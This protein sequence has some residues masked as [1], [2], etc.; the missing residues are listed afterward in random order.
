MKLTFVAPFGLRPKSTVSVRM[1]PL[2]RELVRRGHDVTL[3][4]PPWDNP[5]DSGVE[6]DDHGVHVVNLPLPGRPDPLAASHSVILGEPGAGA[7]GAG[8]RKN[9]EGG[10]GGPNS[11]A[12]SPNRGRPLPMA[13][14]P[15]LTLRLLNRTTATHPDIVHAF[16]PKG[17][18]GAVAQALLARQAMTG[19]RLPV[20]VDTD[21]WEGPGG[22]NDKAA[23]PH[24]QQAI[25]AYQ[26][27]WLLRHAHAVTAA[28]QT[29]VEMA[30]ALREGTGRRG[31]VPQEWAL[32]ARNASVIARSDA[33][34]PWQSG[35]LAARAPD[36]HVAP[37]FMP[38]RR[39]LAMTVQRLRGTPAHLYGPVPGPREAQQQAGPPNPTVTY[40][41]NG[42][43]AVSTTSH[44]DTKALRT[45]LK[46]G[47]APVLLLYTRFV[48]SPPERI[49]QI[50]K[51]IHQQGA[52][53]V[54]LLV[55]AGLNGEEHEFLGAMDGLPVI[56]AGWVP[57]AELPAYF[58]LADGAIFPM[59]DNLL[60]RAKCS[61]KLVDL[62]NAGVPVV[63]EAVGQ[64]TEYIQNGSS[65][66]LVPPD[67]FTVFGK[68]VARLLNDAALR[69]RLSEGAQ[70]R[71]EGSFSWRHLVDRLERTYDQ[72]AAGSSNMP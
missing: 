18:S 48:E 30:L 72:V 9:L 32:W 29:L 69:L 70:A 28:S 21:D 67:D 34:R 23:Y 6:F 17:F 33:G 63:A 55:G 3:L 43:G 51:A 45:R 56:N 40:L 62:L 13:S 24:W 11:R 19:K 14:Y 41:P 64:C 12:K 27:R 37:S 57:S 60:N 47:N 68:A 38:L 35:E 36:C 1:L 66:L 65:G 10:Q 42:P 49:A 50:I 46:L 54:T 58:A 52:H 2:A 31:I 61:V 59:E 4:V 20:V 39:L 53:P 44:P 8:G 15:A 22:W 5:T 26:E 25:F 7:G 71:I 16:K